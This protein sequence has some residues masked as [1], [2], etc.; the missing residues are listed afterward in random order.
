MFDCHMH[1]TFSTDSK[2]EIED[3]IE[4]ASKLNLGIIITEHMD[5]NYPVKG[6]FIFDPK[7]Y[8]SRYEKYKCE[9]VLLGVECGMRSDCINE[10]KKLQEDFPFDFVIG[11]IHLINNMDITSKKLYENKTKKQAYTEYLTSMLNCLK[12]HTFVDTLGHIDYISRYAPYDDSNIYYS[13]FS[14]LI[15]DVL[16]QVI[17]NNMAIEINTRRFK[18]KKAIENLIPIYKRFY[19]LGGR[20]TTVGSDSHFADNIGAHF[21]EALEV[22]DAANL[23]PVYFKNRK[24]EYIKL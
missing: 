1:T 3:A 12:Q 4:R 6:S 15:D 13:E 19:E 20:M 11:S 10:N 9:N 8:F 5:Y 24:P 7:E 16:R 18:D 23:R 17:G 22:A 21:K 14:G 2:M